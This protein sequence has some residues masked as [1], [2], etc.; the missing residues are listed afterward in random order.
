MSQHVAP[1]IDED[2]KQRAEMRHDVGELTLVWPA[3]ESWHQNEVAGGR[4]RQ[5][6]GDALHQREN[7]NLLYRHGRPLVRRACSAPEQVLYRDR[8]PR[9]SFCERRH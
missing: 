5:K 8:A 3:C 1:K 6:F 9:D 4:N 7:D 2:G